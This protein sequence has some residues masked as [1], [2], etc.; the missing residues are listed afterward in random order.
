MN[1]FNQLV[2]ALE[3]KDEISAIL[4]MKDHGKVINKYQEFNGNTILTYAIKNRLSLFANSLLKDDLLLNIPDAYGNTPLHLAINRDLEHLAVQL[5]KFKADTLTNNNSGIAALFLALNKGMQ[6]VVEE[7]VSDSTIINQINND[8]QNALMVCITKYKETSDKKYNDLAKLFI[9]KNINLSY[10]NQI[11]NTDTYKENALTLAI[12]NE[13]IDIA[14]CIIKTG[15]GINIENKEYKRPITLCI[16]KGYENLGNAI[17]YHNIEL[18]YTIN[19]DTA[20]TLAIKKDMYGIADNIVTKRALITDKDHNRNT[21]MS[22]AIQKGLEKLASKMIDIKYRHDDMSYIVNDTDFALTLAIKCN[23]LKIAEEIILNCK[24]IAINVYDKDGNS[25]FALALSKGLDSLC[26]LMINN[27]LKIN[28]YSNEIETHLT[29]AMKLGRIE[30]VKDLVKHN[31]ELK[32]NKKFETPDIIC[33]NYQMN[34]MLKI[35]NTSSN[36]I[37]KEE[38]NLVNQLPVIPFK[39]RTEQQKASSEVKKKIKS[40]L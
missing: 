40:M 6:I 26:K 21:P 32:S 14:K 34:Y 20:L 31:V 24:D 11:Q 29:M 10:S 3:N 25:P 27:G 13:C 39:M 38:S 9:N 8:G 4:I 2:A 15:K 17:L 23:Q 22:L 7:L 33:K 1:Y 37:K 30:I 16:E 5:I 28:D 35:I 12:S 19:G 18:G 36:Y